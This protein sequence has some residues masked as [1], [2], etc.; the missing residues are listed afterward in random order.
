MVMS[1][2]LFGIIMTFSGCKNNKHLN[3]DDEDDEETTEQVDK[4]DKKDKKK[5]DKKKKKQKKEENRKRTVSIE[6]LDDLDLNEFDLE[7]MD[8]NTLTDFDINDLNRE[9]AINL[10]K[11][12]E[13]VA[14]SQLP[15]DMGDGMAL[16]ALA[17]EGDD[18]SFHVKVNPDKMGIT[19][20]QFKKAIDMPQVK[21][22]MI[23]AMS[24]NSDDDDMA[25]FFKICTV[26]GKNMAI[27][28][29]DAQSGDMAVIRLTNAELRN[30]KK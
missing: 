3:Y 29:V 21:N 26:S 1:A 15:V 23:V 22:S 7:S 2:V 16:T 12:V 19:M 6:D 20:E 4:K 28:F 8:M 5:K 25:Q 9:Q 24:G 30:L 14:P 27:K 18:L 17:I 10:L 13:A 11:V